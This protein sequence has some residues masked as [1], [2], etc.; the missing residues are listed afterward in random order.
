M[1][2]PLKALLEAVYGRLVLPSDPPGVVFQKRIFGT[3]C[4][5][6]GAGCTA[7]ASWQR[8]GPYSLVAVTAGML[9]FAFLA[10]ALATRRMTGAMVT[11]LLLGFTAN[12]VLSDWISAA[13][14]LRE[15][16]PLFVL[17]LDLDLVSAGPTWVPYVILSVSVVYLA[18]VRAEG[19]YRYGLHDVADKLG[20]VHGFPQVCEC[21]EP[22]CAH[23][24]LVSSSIIP[25]FVLVVDY[26]VTRNFATTMRV[27]QARLE[28]SASAAHDIAH[29]LAN[30]DLD[31]AALQLATAPNLPA[32][33]RDALSQL[34]SNLTSYRPYLPEALLKQYAPL[35]PERGGGAPGVKTGVAAIAFTDIQASTATW[36][37]CPSA[38]REALRIHNKTV[39]AC[40]AASAG[41]EVKTIGDSFMV[42]FDTLKTA[43]EF[44][45]AVQLG[46]Y[47]EQWPADLAALPTSARVDGVWNG[48]RVRI[49]AHAGAVQVEKS[50]FSDRCDYFGPVANRA[51]R[52]ESACPPGAVAVDAALL[53]EEVD[54][55]ALPEPVVAQTG[56]VHLAGFGSAEVTFL[57]PERLRCRC[58][59]VCEPAAPFRPVSLRSSLTGGGGVALLRRDAT[60]AASTVGRVA[61]QHDCD[62]L[63]L[64]TV[65]RYHDSFL[66]AAAKALDRS[67]GQVIS[68]VGSA[69]YVSWN[70]SSTASA[71]ADSAALFAR[72]LQQLSAAEADPLPISVA[73]C[74]SRHAMISAG[75]TGHRFV[76]ALGAG[77]LL[78]QR[79]ASRAAEL[80]RPALFL[81]PKSGK[82]PLP[83]SLRQQLAFCEHWDVQYRGSAEAKSF[84]LYSVNAAQDNSIVQALADGTSQTT[85]STTSIH[86]AEARVSIAM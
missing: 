52:F 7:H 17:I 86:S 30:F 32:E 21:G 24:S 44:G 54:V 64:D 31:Q 46:L 35:S 11:A 75:I 8:D 41:Y 73:L 49:G 67:N 60:F 82:A 33:L 84:A 27:A 29:A 19:A 36:N 85:T 25:M 13:N 3:V 50:E 28:C 69:V 5:V 81:L 16:W 58:S 23:H 61:L 26:F 77:M 37:A 15:Q 43:V 55:D 68:L 12:V 70:V 48:L 83:V 80:R 51:S 9:S 20:L 76:T 6:V 65:L 53:G 40:A 39:R 10:A 63:P 62:E 45:I 71:H 57:F 4:V 34:L 79:I 18:V 72:L 78:V 56:V 74:A 47:D 42:A 66:A 1:R 59:G 38:M 14:I 2:S 22:P